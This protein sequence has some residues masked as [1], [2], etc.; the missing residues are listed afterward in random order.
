MALATHQ[1][2][3]LVLTGIIF[4]AETVSVMLQVCAFRYFKKRIFKMTPI[5]HHFELIGWAETKITFCFFIITVI[6]S[7]L[8]LIWFKISLY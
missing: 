1:V 8:A 2:F 5:H 7:C 3:L 6:C 4:V